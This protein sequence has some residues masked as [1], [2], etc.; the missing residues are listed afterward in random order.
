MR[1]DPT[2]RIAD[3]IEG[4]RNDLRTLNDRLEVRDFTEF[5][6]SQ[7]AYAAALSLLWRCLLRLDAA[8]HVCSG[9]TF[10]EL[11]AMAAEISAFVVPK[12]PRKQ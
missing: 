12:M 2:E 7:S 6:R 3:E 10:F 5:E 9:P 8:K 4:I 1:R 11:D